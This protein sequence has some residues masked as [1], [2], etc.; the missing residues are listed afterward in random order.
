MSE[1]QLNVLGTELQICGLDPITGYFR[2]GHI[3]ITTS[4]MTDQINSQ[5]TLYYVRVMCIE[6]LCIVCQCI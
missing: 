4:T 2:D 6:S 1:H 3:S 5:N